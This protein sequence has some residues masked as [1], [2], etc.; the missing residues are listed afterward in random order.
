MTW[1]IVN[2]KKNFNDRYIN[3]AE[4]K[5]EEHL[6]RNN[7]PY[8][9]FGWDYLNDP[10]KGSN[11][12]MLPQTMRSLPDFIIFNEKAYFIEVKGCHK[13]LRI[14]QCD[15]QTYSFWN[16][17]MKLFFFIYSTLKD[18]IYKLSYRD[19][20]DISKY[21]EVKVYPDNNKEYYEITNEL[22]EERG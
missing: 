8:K 18:K 19:L 12:Y 1:K 22:L 16:K 5:C 2:Y 14:K 6:K 10:I 20:N 3:L 15:L 9:R 7:I 13:V 21:C 4:D 11:F 17:V